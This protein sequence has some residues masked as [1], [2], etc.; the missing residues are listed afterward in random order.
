[1]VRSVALAL[2]VAS[3]G[4]ADCK[5]SQPAKRAD[6]TNQPAPESGD[7]AP[8]QP[9]VG[10]I[11]FF[12]YESPDGL[13]KVSFP[14]GQPNVAPRTE[15]SQQF[16]AVTGTY[17]QAG[18]KPNSATVFVGNWDTPQLQKVELEAVVTEMRD[19][20]IRGLNGSVL[21]DHR[22]QFGPN[23]IRDVTIGVPDR[24]GQGPLYYRYMI[25][26]RRL[27]RLGIMIDRGTVSEAERDRFFNS[28]TI[29]K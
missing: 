16:G 20:F 29:L 28:F 8:K 6:D 9:L 17:Y 22:Q 26:G 11:P 7:P 27:Y 4:G 21:R 10:G 13:F 3:L 19:L 23:T 18:M 25:H 1:M 2:L 14:W 24:A 5:K 15:N 12:P